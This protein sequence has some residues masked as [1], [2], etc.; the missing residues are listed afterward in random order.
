MWWRQQ[1]S[2]VCVCNL[3]SSLQRWCWWESGKKNWNGE[4]VCC[5]LRSCIFISAGL[6]VWVGRYESWSA[7]LCN[8]RGKFRSVWCQGQPASSTH[9]DPWTVAHINQGKPSAPGTVGAGVCASS[10]WHQ[11]TVTSPWGSNHQCLAH[12]LCTSGPPPEINRSLWCSSNT[13]TTYNHPFLSQV[14]WGRT[15]GKKNEE[16]DFTKHC[17]SSYDTSAKCHALQ[18]VN[19]L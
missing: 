16:N 18:G 3:I 4:I 9:T 1:P 14:H 2:P 17:R 6:S 10:R 8:V 15:D 19:Q 11:M 7:F 12:V 13:Q 5:F